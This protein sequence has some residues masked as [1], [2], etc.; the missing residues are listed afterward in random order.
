MRTS[1]CAMRS[2]IVATPCAAPSPLPGPP[3]S[4]TAEEEERNM[5]GM[6][7]EHERNMGGPWE[8]RRIQHGGLRSNAR[9]QHQRRVAVCASSRRQQHVVVADDAKC[10]SGSL[11]FP[12]PFAL[13]ACAATMH[14]TSPTPR[15]GGHIST[16]SRCIACTR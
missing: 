15:G 10:K 3:A 16:S 14:A 12:P 13:H 6:C 2:K 5:G 8:G 7:E 9:G 4:C 1:P 11:D